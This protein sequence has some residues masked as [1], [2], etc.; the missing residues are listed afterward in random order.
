MTHIKKLLNPKSLFFRLFIALWLLSGGMLFLAGVY[1]N[2]TIDQEFA[3]F[4][5]T[6]Q[7]GERQNIIEAVSDIIAEGDDTR[8]AREQMAINQLARTHNERIIIKDQ[9]G[10]I[11]HDS[12]TDGHG[13]MGMGNGG[14]GGPMRDRDDMPGQGP[15]PDHT[16]DTTEK[17]F[18]EIPSNIIEENTYP[19]EINSETTGS[20]ILLPTDRGPDFF[21]P[22]ELDFRSEI[23]RSI[24]IGGGISLVLAALISSV[25]SVSI[26]RPISNLKETAEGLKEGKL[27][28]RAP[29]KGP[30]E[31]R[32]L[33]LSF[34]AMAEN[35]EK[36]DYL[37]KKLTQDVSHELRNPVASLKGYLEA[38]QDGVL[39][40]DKENITHTINEVQRLENL[41]EELHQLAL[42]DFKER[43]PNKSPLNL[44][45]LAE[46]INATAKPQA[47][48][49]GI[50]FHYKS[51]EEDIIIEADEDLLYRAIKNL[52]QNA[53]NHTEAGGK[54]ELGI[55]KNQTSKENPG[56]S[57]LIYVTDTGKGIPEEKF[58]YVFERFYR[59]D[60]SRTK[61][62]TKSGSGSGLGLSLVKEWTEAMGGT[63]G[64]YSKENQGSTFYLSFPL[65][66][67]H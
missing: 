26:S 7:M 60:E 62:K 34:N 2:F 50:E 49:K 20:I 24:A 56:E 5:E 47:L 48:N 53:L 41:T 21:T 37:K 51:I 25:I 36:N 18:E 39:P 14:M 67:E 4:V 29:I 52:I 44:N 59:A 28:L 27:N 15:R 16:D 57:A 17:P 33:S 55:Q 38:F 30:G 64:A 9:E 13:H 40:T 31:I 12:M 46:K 66:N 6:T 61:E 3:E 23:S 43:K 8:Q 19:L 22:T 54:V 63:V 65:S 10:E 1:I 42:L 11:I 58:P 32:E 35:L 45:E